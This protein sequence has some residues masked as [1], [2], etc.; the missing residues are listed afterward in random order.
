MPLITTTRRSSWVQGQAMF[1]AIG[2]VMK[3]YDERWK[4]SQE[5]PL[6]EYRP[7]RWLTQEGKTAG[8]WQPFGGGEYISWQSCCLDLRKWSHAQAE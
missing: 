7:E 2:L 6:S 5:F 1:L 3:D 8:S 4:G